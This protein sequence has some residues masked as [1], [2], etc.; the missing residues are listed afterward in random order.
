ML[1]RRRGALVPLNSCQEQEQRGRIRSNSKN[2]RLLVVD[3]HI[4]LRRGLVV[5]LRAQ[6]GF[7]IVAEADSAQGAIDGAILFNPDIVLLDVGLRG[8]DG[9]CA[10]S[11]IV[12]TC[13]ATKVVVFSASVDPV[14][15]RGMLAAGAFAYV[16]KTSDC[17]LVLAAIRAALSGSRFLDPDLSGILIEEL[18]TFPAVDRRSRDVLTPRETEVLKRTTWGHTNKEIA[19]EL[20]ISINTVNTYRIRLSEKLG[21][22]GRAELVR[23]GV[24]VGL[25]ATSVQL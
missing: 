22:T 17:T 14:H 11:K 12:R 1:S 7:E 23:Y 21:L 6:T 4:M 9:L 2:I 13:L 5:F 16:L 20:G 25:M 10:A 8:G 15:V 24:A 18:S 3:D 19:A